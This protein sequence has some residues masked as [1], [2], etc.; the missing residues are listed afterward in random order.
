MFVIPQKIKINQMKKFLLAI[1]VLAGAGS[2][3]AQSFTI[4]DENAANVTGAAVYYWIP[5]DY[6]DVKHFIVTNTSANAI[7]V[8][9]R[10]TIM[11]LNTP[12]AVTL[13]CTD[14]NCYNSTT[15][16]SIQFSVAS[17]GTFDL[18]SDYFPDSVSGTGHVR[19]SVINQS[20]MSD[21]TIVDVFYNAVPGPAAIKENVFVKSSISNPAPNP[22]TGLFSISY[23]MG[24]ASPADAKMVV[25]NMLGEKVMETRVEDTEGAVKMDVSTLGQGVYFCSLENDGKLLATRRLVVTH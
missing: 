18:T 14:I 13:F 6:Q 19:Y 17:N 22:A 1:A 9:V 2:L 12:T 10:R 16:M 15:N 23:K 8:K 4:A 7:N 5:Q 24:S 11:Q 20:N 3:S 25:Y 21:S